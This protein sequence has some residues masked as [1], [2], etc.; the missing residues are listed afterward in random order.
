ML[1]LSIHG[2]TVLGQDSIS[3]DGKNY[4]IYGDLVTIVQN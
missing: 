3:Y 1:L 4:M 2:I